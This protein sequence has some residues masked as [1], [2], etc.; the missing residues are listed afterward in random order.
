MI[1]CA[2]GIVPYL[3]SKQYDRRKCLQLAILFNLPRIIVLTIL[4]VIVGIVGFFLKEWI[5]S[6]LPDIFLPVQ[7]IGY[8]FLGLFIL[9]FGARRYNLLKSGVKT[10]K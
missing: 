5:T 10:L 9:I 4:G 3:I 2:P 1:A 6:V 7:A 8:G